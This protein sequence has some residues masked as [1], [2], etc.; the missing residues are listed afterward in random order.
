MSRAL[1]IEPT[2]QPKQQQA[3]NHKAGNILDQIKVRA[4]ELYEARGYVD[5]YDEEDWLQAEHE[6]LN[7]GTADRAA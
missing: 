2:N 6:L 3:K 1:A 5:G 7:Q 4:Y